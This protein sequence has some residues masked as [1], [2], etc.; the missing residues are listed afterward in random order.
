MGAY[1]INK[2]FKIVLSGVLYV[3]CANI[4]VQSSILFTYVARLMFP[5]IDDDAV[6]LLFRFIFAVMVIIVYFIIKSKIKHKY[7]YIITVAISEIIVFPIVL[8]FSYSIYPDNFG[9]VI[10][11]FAEFAFLLLVLCVMLFDV[12]I[13]FVK[14]AFLKYEESL[15]KKRGMQ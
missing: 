8:I 6:N 1:M 9:Y 15:R 12:A 5:K 10:Y 13:Q 14:F 7:T 2:S 4:L 3:L 11:I